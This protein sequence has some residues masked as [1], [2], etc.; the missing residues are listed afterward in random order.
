MAGGLQNEATN[1]VY[2]GIVCYL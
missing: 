2:T 1:T